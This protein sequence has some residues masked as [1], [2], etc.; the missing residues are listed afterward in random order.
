MTADA[1][2]PEDRQDITIEIDLRGR[3]SV[4]KLRPPHKSRAQ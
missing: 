4:R 1:V 3:L 2:L